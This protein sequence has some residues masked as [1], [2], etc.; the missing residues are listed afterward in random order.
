MDLGLELAA[1]RHQV[2][3]LKRKNPRP[4][5]SP[6]DRLFWLTLQRWWYHLVRPRGA[7][8]EGRAAADRTVY[9]RCESLR[10][11]HP[12]WSVKIGSPCYQS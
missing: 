11:H 4:Q 7:T 2:A 3:V 10:S 5:L 1:L 6:W 12:V 9:E 8:E